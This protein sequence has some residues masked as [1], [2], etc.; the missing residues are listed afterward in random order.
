MRDHHDEIRGLGAEVVAVATATHVQAAALQPEMP[1]PLLVDPEFSFREALG[2]H[3]RFR[4][5]DLFTSESSRNY[6]RALRRGQRQGMVPP[7]H[8]LNRP[9]MVIGA[10][11]GTVAWA[12]EG[13]S[14]GDYPA[15]DRVLE[16]LRAAIAD[17]ES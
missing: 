4:V 14:V 5:R 9:A 2:V 17:A 7:R 1:F 8:A 15:V 10:P 3:G 12:H 16:V 13:A 11:D 6:L